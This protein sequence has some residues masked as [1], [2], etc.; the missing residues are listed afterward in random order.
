PLALAGA[1]IAAHDIYFQPLSSG[2]SRIVQIH[3]RRADRALRG[4][5][6]DVLGSHDLRRCRHQ[7]YYASC[8]QRSFDHGAPRSR[9]I[10]WDGMWKH[11]RRSP[12]TRSDAWTIYRP[13]PITSAPL[14]M[15]QVLECE[16]RDRKSTR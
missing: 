3:R 4:F 12:W 6:L 16:P 9:S 8:I 14:A 15:S 1:D 2:G 11:R 7:A 10:P 13:I 5:F